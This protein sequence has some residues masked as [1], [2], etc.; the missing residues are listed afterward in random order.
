MSKAKGG[1]TFKKIVYIISISIAVMGILFLTGK[2]FQNL[3][4]SSKKEE[5]MQV[6]IASLQLASASIKNISSTER[7]VDD[8]AK[9]TS[10]NSE[11]VTSRSLTDVRT[12]TES[13][14]DSEKETNTDSEKN[15]ST[16]TIK[17]EKSTAT[18]SSSSKKKSEA[19]KPSSTKKDTA[20]EKKNN[21]TNTADEQKNSKTNTTTKSESKKST[22]KSTVS[23]SDVTISKTM[24]L[25]KR[26][27]L[28]REDFIKLISGVKADT[29]GFFE[30]NAGTIYDLCKTYSI[31]EIFFCGLISAE[32]G[33]NIASNHRS[34]HNYISLMKNGKLISYSSVYEG[35]K[36][37]AQK[38]HNN[39]LTVGGKFYH[40]KTLTGVKTCFCPSSTWVSLV[41]GRMQQII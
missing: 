24:D 11:N 6:K 30:D 36:V 4:L 5:D 37:A 40:G 39:Y 25:T 31:N 12:D 1:L 9:P 14:T 33:W 22:T 13:L 38:L 20:D 10:S 34:T 3:K 2:D 7:I 19:T 21:K 28:S 32:S 41:Y 17:S 18:K 23:I 35:L 16:N 15:T 27:G 8:S 26:T 29:S